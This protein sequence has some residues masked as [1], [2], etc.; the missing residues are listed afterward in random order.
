MA[1]SKVCVVGS[2]TMGSGIAQVSAQAGYETTMVDIKQEF[3]DR[4]MSNIKASLGKFVEKGRMKQEEM[5]E[6][7]A[8]LRTTVDMK[9]AARDADYVIEAAFERAE[10][11]LPIF[12]QLEDVCRKET[13]LASNTSGIPVSLLASAT[14]RPDKVIGTHFMNPVPLMKGV[15]IVRSLLTSDETLSTSLDFVKSLGKETVVVKDSPGFVTNRIVTLVF[16]EAAK[17]LEENLASIEDIDKIEK[18]SHNWPMGPFELADLVGIDVVVD[19]LEGIY[20]ET[21]WERYKPAPLLKRMVEI[22][23]T[24]RKAGKGFYQLFAQ[25]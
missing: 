20:R 16:N 15:E 11:K 24:G 23:Y 12:A 5:G 25:G 10:V 3:L 4:G 9:D 17:L 7:L 22:G 1:I 18:L 6:T 13:I 19:L 14:R 2:G 21:G 8:R